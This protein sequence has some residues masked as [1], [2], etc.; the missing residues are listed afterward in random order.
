[1]KRGK[2]RGG[3]NGEIAEIGEGER[4]LREGEREEEVDLAELEVFVGGEG[5]DA[6]ADE[7]FVGVAEEEV[8]VV[9]CD[10]GGFDWIGKL[11]DEAVHVNHLD[12]IQ[13]WLLL[14]M[15]SHSALRI[16]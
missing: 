11:L 16:R 15:Q 4:R 12:R 8:R 10:F 13:I 5:G 6:A 3:L 7:H 2:S 1:M 14:L 9:R